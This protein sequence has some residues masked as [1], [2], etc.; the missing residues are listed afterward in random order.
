MFKL[1]GTF[2]T[3][4]GPKY[5]QQLCKHFAH[6]IDVTHSDTEGTCSF[7]MGQAV[8]KADDAGLTIRFEL[9]DQDAVD[10][11]RNVIDSHLE[12][13]AFRENFKHMTWSA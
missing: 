6:K 1:T 9:K 7:P 4:N 8:L 13:F 11:A 12:R 10:P 3:Q 2:A 5:L